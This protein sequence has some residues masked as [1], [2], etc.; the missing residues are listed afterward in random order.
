LLAIAEER[1]FLASNYRGNETTITTRIDFA[2]VIRNILQLLPETTNV[3]IVIG[4]S[5]IVGS[6]PM[7][8]LAPRG[9]GRP[10]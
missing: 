10:R 6:C 9:F 5:P 1:R 4:N 8:T 3:A 7:G 2:E